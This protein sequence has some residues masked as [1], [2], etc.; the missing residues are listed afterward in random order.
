MESIWSRLYHFA[1]RSVTAARCSKERRTAY[2]MTWS[3]SSMVGE[4]ISEQAVDSWTLHVERF[5][6]LK[7]GAQLVCSFVQR[8]LHDSNHWW[9]NFRAWARNN[10]HSSL[11]SSS[12][13][14]RGENRTRSIA[15][16]GIK[17]HISAWNAPITIQLIKKVR[18][19]YRTTLPYVLFLFEKWKRFSTYEVE[20]W[21]QDL[22]SRAPQTT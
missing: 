6:F 18:H 17:S 19:Y 20:R 22:T 13:E 9:G 4:T 5:W 3:P 11:T 15:T 2:T 21:V 8:W 1:L 7:V 14:W 16:T 10:L 12:T